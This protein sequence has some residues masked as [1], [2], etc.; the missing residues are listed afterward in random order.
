MKID[1][2]FAARENSVFESCRGFN[3]V[4]QFKVEFRGWVPNGLAGK[5]GFRLNYR[6][7]GHETQPARFEAETGTVHAN[8][9][10]PF[11][12]RL[13][14]LLHRH[15][16]F[17]LCVLL[18]TSVAVVFLPSLR[19]D[20]V[21]Y[22]DPEYVT[23]NPQVQKG[24]TWQGIRWAFVTTA[25]SNW[26]PLTWLSHMADCELFGQKSW[27]HHLTSVMVH[28]LNTGLLFLVLRGMTGA[29]WRSLLVACLFGL[30][31]LRVQSVA[32]VA[33]RK[34]VLSALFWMLTL[35]AYAHYAKRSTVR[36]GLIQSQSQVRPR[37]FSLAFWYLL[38]LGFF[39]FGLMSKPMVV[40]LPFVLLLLD[41]WPLQRLRPFAFTGTESGA[42]NA[43]RPRSNLWHLGLEKIPFFIL[44]AAASIVTFLVQRDSGAL[45]PLS[46]MP[47][48]LARLDNALIGY[49]R[50]LGK[51]FY[52]IDL[53]AYYPR[54][55][56]WP[57]LQVVSAV[58]LL[59]GISAAA[60]L[61]RRRRPYLVVGWL[62]YLGTLVPAIGLVQVGA[63]SIADRYTYIPIIGVSLSLVWS[64]HDLIRQ[65]HLRRLSQSAVAVAA[66]TVVLVCAA[67]TRW[68]I[69]FWAN[70]ETLFRRSLSVTSDNPLARLNLGAALGEKGRAEEGLSHLQAALRLVPN[71]ADLQ[72]TVGNA[73][74]SIGYPQEAIV[75]LQ[76]SL[77][78]EPR[79]AQCHLMLGKA[80]EKTGSLDEAIVHYREAIKL[81]PELIDARDDLGL[82]LCNKGQFGEAIDQFKEAIRFDPASAKTHDFLGFAL[83]E[84]GKQDEAIAEFREAIRLRPGFAETYNRLGIILLT[85]GRLEEALQQFQK[86]LEFNSKYVE[87]LIYLGL[88]HFNLGD[89]DRAADQYR[90]ALALEPNNVI[91]QK[92]LE[93][94]LARKRNAAR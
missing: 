92:N 73:M 81:K 83:G 35:W 76:Q 16:V 33:E 80:F 41:Y 54:P 44:S 88:T 67:I 22:D 90:Q 3:V 65:W 78:A 31:P 32:W 86:A 1:D 38:A 68:Q 46:G 63:Q 11:S 89:L 14:G 91:A 24:L 56:A 71:D 52:P 60:F 19:N 77:A 12:R 43:R 75:P 72:F 10:K 94:V 23:D 57:A 42:A 82:A 20:F 50:Y 55:D 66:V 15:Q 8:S 39:A 2:F 64:M 49:C 17:F 69:G 26:H 28:A 87:A 25:A 6:M 5:R 4:C 59:L 27:G 70:S 84:A 18:M 40:T 7:S 30:H 62:W 51:F 37:D 34:D 48:L 58:S 53:A 45:R 36:V 79:R 29:V 21:N 61:L 85:S 47:S 93:L 74:V 13:Q 9:Q